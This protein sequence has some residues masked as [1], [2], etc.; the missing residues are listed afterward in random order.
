M[1][2]S[3][4]AARQSSEARLARRKHRDES[5]RVKP[6]LQSSWRKIDSSRAAICAIRI[7]QCSRRFTGSNRRC[8]GFHDQADTS[9]DFTIFL[10][11][12]AIRWSKSQLASIVL[13]NL[14]IYRIALLANAAR[15]TLDV[16]ETTEAISSGFGYAVAPKPQHNGASGSRFV[17]L[18]FK[19]HSR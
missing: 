6:I 13:S 14:L 8:L 11:T 17:V 4:S 2:A 18:A 16:W 19:K 15:S 3:T 9:P 10:N 5:G 12:T 7:R 1:P